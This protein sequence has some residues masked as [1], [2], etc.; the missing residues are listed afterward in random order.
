MTPRGDR[1]GTTGGSWRVFDDLDEVRELI[2]RYDSD[3]ERDVL[4][5]GPFRWALQVRNG[6]RVQ[7]GRVRTSPQR[8]RGTPR[9]FILH[10]AQ[11]GRVTYDVRGRLVEAFPGQ[12]VM[13]AP[14][15]TF[16]SWSSGSTMLSVRVQEDALRL[17]AACLAGIDDPGRLE[18]ET[19]LPL[20][21]PAGLRLPTLLSIKGIGTPTWGSRD[22]PP[23]WEREIVETVARVWLETMCLD[24]G[25]NR[26]GD[27]RRRVRE[28]EEWVDAHFTRPITLGE[29]CGVAGVSAR[30]LHRM[31]VRHRGRPPM[32]HVV[33]RRLAVAR[34][35]LLAGRPGDSVMQV[36]FESG[37]NHLGRFAGQYRAAYGELPSESLAPR[38]PRGTGRR[39]PRG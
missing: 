17:E 16:A 36:A 7:V 13:L 32:K 37:F 31:F 29:L 26:A 6:S 34:S 9:A 22:Q 1:L 3:H 18:L 38:A 33:E 8:L 28:V 30:T 35:R 11:G 39:T 15:E 19:V 25:R 23:G 2:A 24:L 12:A 21:T 10:V 27:E 14:G 20:H 5:P 4:R